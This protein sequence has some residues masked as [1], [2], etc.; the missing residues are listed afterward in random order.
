MIGRRHLFGL[1]AASPLVL[2]VSARE[3][4]EAFL[5]RQEQIITFQFHADALYTIR[6]DE[7]QNVMGWVNIPA[8]ET[9]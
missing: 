1:L 3:L 7:A 2:T 6:F 5:A 8:I 9:A 4:D